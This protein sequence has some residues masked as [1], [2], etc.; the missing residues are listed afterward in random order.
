MAPVLADSSESSGKIVRKISVEIKNCLAF[1]IRIET[2]V[3]R[4]LCSPCIPFRHR[5]TMS[6]HKENEFMK[7]HLDA[8]V[9]LG[10][11]WCLKILLEHEKLRWLLGGAA[12]M[13]QNV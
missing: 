9:V 11:F 5:P 1:P 10:G 6:L 13:L 12:E 3:L 4:S 2:Q 7:F 8:D